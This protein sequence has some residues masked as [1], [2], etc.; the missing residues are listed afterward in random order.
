MTS[1]D[2]NSPTGDEEL[3]AWRRRSNEVR[4]EQIKARAQDGSGR[5]GPAFDL[6]VSKILIDDDSLNFK[7]LSSDELELIGEGFFGPGMM[8]GPT[9]RANLRKRVR[10]A[11]VGPLKGMIFPHTA[12]FLDWFE[13]WRLQ[14][15]ANA[16]QLPAARAKSAKSRPKP[17][18]EAVKR[19]RDQFRGQYQGKRLAEEIL[20][21]WNLE[22]EASGKKP[23]LRKTVE[24]Y[25]SDLPD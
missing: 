10:Q 25:L 8:F 9:T 3:R 1:R 24:N 20:A 23:V 21:A 11:T 13:T 16:L 6:A 14:L 5:G 7:A 2:D 17:A 15:L 19:L 4:L 18:Q 22:R 12:E